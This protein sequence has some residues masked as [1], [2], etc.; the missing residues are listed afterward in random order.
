MTRLIETDFWRDSWNS[1]DRNMLSNEIDPTVSRGN[2]LF[3]R[4]ITTTEVHG[5]CQLGETGSKHLRSCRLEP[6]LSTEP[7]APRFL[8]IQ[9]EFQEG[10]RYRAGRHGPVKLEFQRK[11]VLVIVTNENID[12]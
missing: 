9:P 2:G 5:G 12:R 1:N 4:S 7:T 3:V 10:T 6:S 8:S 11:T